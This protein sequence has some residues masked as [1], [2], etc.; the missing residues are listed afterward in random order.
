MGHSWILECRTGQRCAFF[1]PVPVGVGVGALL[2]VCWASGCRRR[3]T[4]RAESGVG[5]GAGVKRWV[6]ALQ[7]TDTHWRHPQG[8][9]QQ[10]QLDLLHAALA[11]FASLR[12]TT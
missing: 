5:V 4:H 6:Y 7:W 11:L 12:R 10:E 1:A 8:E 3:L 9:L 2:C